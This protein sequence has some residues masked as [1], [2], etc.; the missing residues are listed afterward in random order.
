MRGL[1][2]KSGYS[3]TKTDLSDGQSEFLQS[4]HEREGRLSLSPTLARHG[5]S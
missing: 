2:M 3:W 4:R 5:T 1:H